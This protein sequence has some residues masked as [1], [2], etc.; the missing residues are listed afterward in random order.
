MEEYLY[1]CQELG[2]VKPVVGKVYSL[3]DAAQAQRDVIDHSEG[4][5]GKI[6]LAI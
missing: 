4:S 3:E 5:H 6:I 1:R 2:L